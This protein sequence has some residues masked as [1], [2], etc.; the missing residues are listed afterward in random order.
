MLAPRQR[1][2]PGPMSA[3]FVSVETS[4]DFALPPQALRRASAPDSAPTVIPCPDQE[5]APGRRPFT[6][7]HGS[8]LG[9]DVRTMQTDSAPCVK[10]RTAM[11]A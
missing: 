11:E 10:V 8:L 6:R 9:Q 2:P 1:D 5:L 3:P 7:M 4:A